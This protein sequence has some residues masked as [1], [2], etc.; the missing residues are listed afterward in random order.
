MSSVEYY[1]WGAELDKMPPASTPKLYLTWLDSV[2]F[3]FSVDYLAKPK[4]DTIHE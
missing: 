2:D 4:Y 3:T 1:I